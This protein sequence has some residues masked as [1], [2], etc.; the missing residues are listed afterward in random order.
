MGERI[1]AEITP[2]LQIRAKVFDKPDKRIIKVTIEKALKK[3]EAVE[4][5]GL[6]GGAS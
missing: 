1:N 3:L 2:K 5:A 4:T 6:N